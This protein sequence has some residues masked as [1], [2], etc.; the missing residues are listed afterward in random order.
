MILA[1]ENI[2][3]VGMGV[4]TRMETGVRRIQPPQLTPGKTCPMPLLSRGAHREGAAELS[5]GKSR[6]SHYGAGDQGY[7]KPTPTPGRDSAPGH[8]CERAGR[9]GTFLLS[10]GGRF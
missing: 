2:T 5:A 10:V 9:V 3:S 4:Q 7:Q 6:R 8:G 1:P